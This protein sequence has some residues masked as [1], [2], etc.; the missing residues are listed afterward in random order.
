MDLL[1]APALVE[2]LDRQPVEQL[3]VAG[4]RAL[5]AEVVF[6]FDDAEP[7]ELLPEA[8]H[9][10]PRRQRVG[11]IDQPLGQVEAIRPKPGPLGTGLGK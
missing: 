3:R 11:R 8:V 10:N 5:G 7:E 4:R 2:Q 1:E 9:D 6:G